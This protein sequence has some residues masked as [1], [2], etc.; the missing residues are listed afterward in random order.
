MTDRTSGHVGIRE[1][2]AQLSELV[3]RVQFRGDTIAVTKN[4]KRVAV[5]VP[6]EW[7]DRMATANDVAYLLQQRHPELLAELLREVPK[8]P[9]TVTEE[10]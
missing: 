3:G 1:F 5:L 4:G 8:D 7:Y 10:L 2:K 6:A 9:P